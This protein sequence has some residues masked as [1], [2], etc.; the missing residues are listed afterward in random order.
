MKAWGGLYIIVGVFAGWSS[1][2]AVM[3]SVNGSPDRWW[4]AFALGAAIL[5]F[6]DGIRLCVPRIRAVLLVLLTGAIP[7]LI[8][9]VF[10]EWPLRVW[11]FSAALALL[12]ALALKACAVT[13]RNGIS[14]FVS[15]VVLVAA[16]ANTTIQL[17][18]LYWGGWWNGTSQWTL[19]QIAGFMLPTLIP[20][21]ILLAMLVHATNV[22]FR[23]QS[24][25]AT[26]PATGKQ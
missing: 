9:I 8:S 19:A 6:T 1:L 21:S 3:A 23:S 4:P 12:E 18:F 10:M 24:L 14:T 5:L 15:C 2:G 7:L 11:V 13:R 26:D 16:L 20:W 25:S 22:L 17:F